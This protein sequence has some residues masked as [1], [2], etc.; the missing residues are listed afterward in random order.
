MSYYWLNKEKLL[1][2]HGIS[3]TIK[4]ENKKLP[5]ITRKMQT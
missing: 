3:I 4:K 1:K 2:M 5:N